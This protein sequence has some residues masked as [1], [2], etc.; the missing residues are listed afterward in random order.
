MTVFY[1]RVAIRIP[2]AQASAPSNM[3]PPMNTTHAETT[4]CSARPPNPNPEPMLGSATNTMLMS[5]EMMS[6]ADRSSWTRQ[7]QGVSSRYRAEQ[8]K[9]LPAPRQVNPPRAVLSPRPVDDTR[10]PAAVP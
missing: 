10:Q 7:I 6:H 8:D 3:N 2:G 5:K 4:H 9:V 1:T